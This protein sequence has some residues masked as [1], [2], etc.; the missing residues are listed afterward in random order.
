MVK[1][2][3][4]RRQAVE[5]SPEGPESDRQF[6]RPVLDKVSGRCFGL[7]AATLTSRGRVFLDEQ[8]WLVDS[9]GETD[10][11]TV[12]DLSLSRRV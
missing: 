7:D 4:L 10:S 1:A 11:R 9:V 3:S 2:G 8:V 6:S 12:N 5:L